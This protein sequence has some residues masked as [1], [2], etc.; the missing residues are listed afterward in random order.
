[1]KVARL[2]SEGA[3]TVRLHIYDVAWSPHLQDWMAAVWTAGIILTP[4]GN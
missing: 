3:V 1:M 4:K 2:I